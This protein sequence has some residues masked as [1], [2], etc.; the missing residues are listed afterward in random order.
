MNS[1][2]TTQLITTVSGSAPAL[3]P[4]I[5]PL[6]LKSTTDALIPSWCKSPSTSVHWV[7]WRAESVQIKFEWNDTESLCVYVNFPAETKA[8][9]Q[10]NR[11]R[12]LKALFERHAP[13]GKKPYQDNW[14]HYRYEFST[15]QFITPNDAVAL[16]NELGIACTVIYTSLTMERVQFD[17][18]MQ[19]LGLDVIIGE[20]GKEWMDGAYHA[21]RPRTGCNL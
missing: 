2:T 9:S 4:L 16:A 12:V 6:V 15:P 17:S 11:N 14:G 5:D 18:I 8:Q 21:Y 10:S 1:N 20:T 7:D 19:N 3:R 13:V